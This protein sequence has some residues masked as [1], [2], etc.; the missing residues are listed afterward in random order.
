MIRP[1]VRPLLSLLFLRYTRWR[2]ARLA[3]RV[4]A[5]VADYRRSGFDVVG[6]IGIDGS[7]SCGVTRTLDLDLAIAGVVACDPQTVVRDAFNQDVIIA[8]LTPGEGLFTAALRHALGQ[9]RLDIH[10][11]AHDLVAELEGRPTRPIE[12]A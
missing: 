9:R 12:L 10:L 4:A 1:P 11:Y 2:Y 8:S 5:D 3:R 7:P 6:I